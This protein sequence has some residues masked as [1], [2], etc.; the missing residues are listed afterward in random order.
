MEDFRRHF[1]F[2]FAGVS[3]CGL[4]QEIKKPSKRNAGDLYKPKAGVWHHSC[5]QG[6]FLD[7]IKFVGGWGGNLLLQP[8]AG[9]HKASMLNAEDQYKPI[10]G[11]WHNPLSSVT[12]TLMRIS[13]PG[14]QEG[15]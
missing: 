5:G 7:G 15:K 9:V 6:Y 2:S 12:A 11:V 1:Y 3:F 4:K 14:D 10:A 8:Q 13:L